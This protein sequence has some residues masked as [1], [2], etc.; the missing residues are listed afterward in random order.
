MRIANLRLGLEHGICT[1]IDHY[2]KDDVDEELYYIAFKYT[3]F[4]TKVEFNPPRKWSK[5]I[6]ERYRIREA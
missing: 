4:E 5:Y 3:Q 2:L 6:L 1:T